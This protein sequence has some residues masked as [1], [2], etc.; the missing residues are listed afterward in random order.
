MFLCY[1]LHKCISF[2]LKPSTIPRRGYVSH[3]LPLSHQLTDSR[4]HL[5]CMLIGN[6]SII[7]LRHNNNLVTIESMLSFINYKS[8]VTA[9]SFVFDSHIVYSSDNIKSVVQA[10]ANTVYIASKM[11][12]EI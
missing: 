7:D 8:L 10:L 12:I 6:A 1:H 11:F 4:N 5:V 3:F 9:M 2:K